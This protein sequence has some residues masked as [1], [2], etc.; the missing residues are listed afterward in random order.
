MKTRIIVW[1][2]ILFAQL[3]SAGVLV[4]TMGEHLK[5]MVACSVAF[6]AGSLI[7]K[8]NRECKKWLKAAKA[9]E[10]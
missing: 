6:C 2:V 3:L 8:L 5:A 4:A 10:S 1:S 7:E 9:G